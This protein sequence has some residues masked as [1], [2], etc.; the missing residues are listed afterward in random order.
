MK[1]AFLPISQLTKEPYSVI[2]GFPKPTK[3]QINSRIKELKKLG[4]NGVM[5]EGELNLGQVNV[6]GKGYV[7]I[8][9]LA[10]KGKK[11]VALKIRRRDSPRKEMN[12]EAKLLKIAN[13]VGV[14]PP[15]VD[16]S[17][18]ILVM[19][20]LPGKKIGVWIKELKTYSTKLKRIL[21]KILEDCYKLDTVGLD[22]GELSCI[23]KHVIIEKETPTIIDLESASTKRKVSNVTAATQGIFIG[24]GI[25]KKIRKIYKV[26]RKQ[27]IIRVLREYKNAKTRFNFDNILKI[28]RV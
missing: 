27:K 19:E 3:T 18:N 4:I 9:V 25:S 7:G 11:K 14:G 22:H 1:T 20:Y 16:N 8:V 5:F 21:R 15:L 17:K 10:R 6:L 23:S 28:V 26:P 24:S 2:L 12:T 13:S